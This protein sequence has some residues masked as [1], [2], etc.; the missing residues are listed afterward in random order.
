MLGHSPLRAA[1]RRIAIHQLSLL[2][3]AACAS[4]STTTTTTRDRGDRYGPIEW[5]QLVRVSVYYQRTA[6][7]HSIRHFSCLGRNT[8]RFVEDLCGVEQRRHEPFSII[9]VVDVINVRHKLRNNASFC[10]R[11]ELKRST[12]RRIKF[13]SSAVTAGFGAGIRNVQSAAS[14]WAEMNGRRTETAAAAGLLSQ[15]SHGSLPVNFRAERHSGR[16]QRRAATLQIHDVYTLIFRSTQTAKYLTNWT[17][18]LSVSSVHWCFCVEKPIP[19]DV[20]WRYFETG[21]GAA[22]HG[23]ARQGT[24]PYGAAQRQIR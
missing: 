1:A 19:S 21:S 22:R 17:T 7:R 24:V 15:Y 6:W 2:S 18:A 10:R 16:A 14:F 8:G 11:S 5:A 23:M 20:D 13:I 9:G 3:H 12:L 4:M